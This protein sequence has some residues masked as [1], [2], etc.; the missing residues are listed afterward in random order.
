MRSRPDAL[1][2]R[3][4]LSD[5]ALLI[6]VLPLPDAADQLVIRP[7]ERGVGEWGRIFKLLVGKLLLHNVK[8][9]AG[10]NK[11]THSHACPTLERRASSP[12]QCLFSGRVT[13]HGA[14][15]YSGA[16]VSS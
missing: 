6:L 10:K 2:H 5:D 7:L 14:N 4:L 15:G 9:H 13:A 3:L 12:P 11:N 8:L 1:F 16:R